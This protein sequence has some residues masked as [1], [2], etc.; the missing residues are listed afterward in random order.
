ML[1]LIVKGN[2]SEAR[3]AC[4]YNGITVTSAKEHER[5][6][7][8]TIRTDDKFE[9]D[10]QKWFITS[11]RDDERKPAPIGTLMWYAILPARDLTVIGNPGD[12]VYLLHPETPE[13]VA[14]LD[15]NL[16]V[17]PWQVMDNSIAIEHGYIEAIVNG[18][19]EDGLTVASKASTIAS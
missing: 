5:F 8:T 3:K 6:N 1:T 4:E 9:R 15:R 10:A 2:E 13:G 18:A 19:R 16:Y 12:T 7:E 11:C 14:W 17:E